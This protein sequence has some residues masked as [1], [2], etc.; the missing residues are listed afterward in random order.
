[1]SRIKHT[2]NMIKYI[3][4]KRNIDL[5]INQGKKIYFILY[6]FRDANLEKFSYSFLLPAIIAQ[7]SITG[8]IL[9]IGF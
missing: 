4:E 1:M 8:S 9:K 5:L 7:T 3:G 6:T 2:P